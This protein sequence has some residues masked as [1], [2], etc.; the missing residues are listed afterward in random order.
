MIGLCRCRF[1]L[2]GRPVLISSEAK[3]PLKISRDGNI[4]SDA[5]GRVL[6]LGSRKVREPVSVTLHSRGYCHG[7]KIGGM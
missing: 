2:E 5:C 3:C 6:A 4:L 7:F 1:A